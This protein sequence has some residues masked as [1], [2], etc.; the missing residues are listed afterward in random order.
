MGVLFVVGV[1]NL[2]WVAA[3]AAFVLVE[4]AIPRGRWVSR[5]SGAALCLWGLWLASSVWPR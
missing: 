3:I 4:K 1:M 2:A 5:L